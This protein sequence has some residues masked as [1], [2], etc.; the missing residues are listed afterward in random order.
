M[1]F[2]YNGF[3]EGIENYYTLSFTYK[4][5]YPE[6]EVWFAHAVPYTYTDLMNELS[7]LRKQEEAKQPTERMLEASILCRTLA[8]VPCPLLTITSDIETYQDYYEEVKIQHELP[9]VVKKQL[10][11]KY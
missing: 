2:N 10:R 8:G 11:Q 7:K 9:P 6:D 5:E 4:F 3:G 1:L